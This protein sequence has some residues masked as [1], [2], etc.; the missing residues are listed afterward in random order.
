[1]TEI[2]VNIMTFLKHVNGNLSHTVGRPAL[3]DLRETLAQ[4]GAFYEEFVTK[5]L[6]SNIEAY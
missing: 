1:M 6:K 5:I 3:Q 2:S 4:L